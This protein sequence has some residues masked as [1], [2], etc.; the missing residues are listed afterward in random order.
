MQGS[1]KARAFDSHAAAACTAWRIAA[2][3]VA[4]QAR[5]GDS[6]PPPP[7]AWALPCPVELETA[8]VDLS[9]WIGVTRNLLTTS[10]GCPM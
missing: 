10:H 3:A 1:T 7:M 5:R 9:A 4:A 6:C 8:A 2:A